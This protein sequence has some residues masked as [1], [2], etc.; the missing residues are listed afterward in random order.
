MSS[1]RLGILMA[2]TILAVGSATSEAA[3]QA[4][5]TCQKLVLTGEVNAGQEWKQAI[6]QGWMFRVL[7]IR[8][9]STAYSGWDLVVDRERPAGFP[10]ALYLAT[11]PYGSLNEREVGTTFGLRA[12]DAIGWNPRSFRFLSSGNALAEG[13]QLYASLGANL[14]GS[15]ASNRKLLELLSQSVPGEFRI[16]DARLT[17]GIGDAAPYA[18]NW[19]V[20]F[21][22]TP[23]TLVPGRAGSP[24][25]VG[26]IQWIKFSITL[27]LPARWTTPA[28]ATVTKAACP[29]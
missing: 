11:L 29:E 14:K 2:A 24:T 22:K 12:Q 25:A 19:E 8:P 6:G 18:V 21:R 7:P 20:A 10:D 9:E 13:Q 4:A 23:H 26:E 15:A 3:P 5:A 27:W 28:G 17:A 16:L 1:C